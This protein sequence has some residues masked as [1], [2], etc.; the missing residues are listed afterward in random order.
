MYAIRS[1][2]VDEK[3]GKDYF[4]FEMQAMTDFY[5][6]INEYGLDFDNNPQAKQAIP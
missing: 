6:V 3:Q 1:Y 4:D 5:T 2:Y